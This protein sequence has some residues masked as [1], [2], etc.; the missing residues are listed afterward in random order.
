MADAK[1]SSMVDSNAP[2]SSISHHNTFF[3]T[4]SNILRILAIALS[5]ASIAVTTTNK[6]TVVL[7]TMLFDARFY[8]SSSLKF[9]VAA[10]AVV[11]ALSVVTLIMNFLLGK[12]AS[13]RK[14]YYLFLFIHDILMTVLLMAGCAA[15]TAIGYVGQF[16]EDHMGWLPMCDHVRKFCT[17]NL[18][19]VVLSY[20]AFFA[21]LGLNILTAH[22]CISFAPKN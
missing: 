19:S 9:F 8:Y 10:N 18:I 1:D 5:A 7:F 15:A 22:R 3:M 16:G 17:T 12:Q 11:C 4:H 20:L 6:E 13:Q 14:E 21:Y 2:N